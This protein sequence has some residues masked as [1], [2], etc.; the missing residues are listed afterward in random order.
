VGDIRTR[1]RSILGAFLFQGD[2]IEKKVK[3]L[4]G[5]ERSRLSLIKLLLAPYNLLILDEPT[6]H[7]DMR[8]KEILKTALLEY[9]GTL[10]LVS[11]D[12][13]FLDG[14]TEKIYE[15]KNRNIKENIGGIY[16]F[17]KKQRIDSL[18]DL[19]K[20]RYHTKDKK[21]GKTDPKKKFILRK[22]SEKNIRKLKNQIEK[23][24]SEISGLE[25]KIRKLDE[26][27]ANPE[28]GVESVQEDA[29]YLSY[30]ELQGELKNRLIDWEKLQLKMESL[31]GKTDG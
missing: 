25:S 18:A 8:S 11:H 4:S 24:E 14:L 10:V 29:V 27:F 12:R 16:D 23:L 15:F 2:D 9:K 20:V 28:T 19:E 13:E 26:Q 21:E 3:V 5:G 30:Q 31:T 17:L 22:E 7:L 1:I 6:N